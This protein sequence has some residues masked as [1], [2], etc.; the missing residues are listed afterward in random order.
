MIDI[1]R[2]LPDLVF[3]AKISHSYFFRDGGGILS[4]FAETCNGLLKNAAFRC[5]AA[6]SF[7]FAYLLAFLFEGQLL[8]SVAEFYSYDVDILLFP[9]VGAHF[10]GL[11]SGWYF[12]RSSAA[13]RRAQSLLCLLSAILALPF[14]FA[15]TVLWL[16]CITMASFT[17]GIV[18]ASWGFTLRDSV[19]AGERLIVCADTL[20][21]SNLLMILFN[22]TAVHISAMAGLALSVA[23]AVVSSFLS[24]LPMKIEE[25]AIYTSS[26]S[27]ARPLALLCLFVFIITID[28][29]L[30]Y[31]VL[32][33]AFAHLEWLVSWYW[34]LPYIAALAILRRPPRGFR[35]SWALYLGMTMI[36]LAFAL[37]MFVGRGA[38]GYLIVDTLMLGACG[39][40]DLFWW[41]LAASF[42]NF[43][44]NPARVFG[45]CLAAN[46]LGVLVGGLAG[47]AITSV[48]VSEHAAPLIALTVVCVTMGLLP[49][50]NGKLLTLL[51]E[52]SFL[53]TYF[54]AP[55]HGLTAVYA[56]FAAKLTERERD[57]LP[58]LLAGKKNKDIGEELCLSESTVKFHVNN[59]YKKCGVNSRT[60]LIVKLS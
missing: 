10:L 15:P 12:I 38:A 39:I 27:L 28:S 52:H 5:A 44:K 35:R 17:A 37:F 50:L 42:L 14:F 33:P 53:L 21:F 51:G 19:P 26:P 16:P 6:F 36:V 7:F 56:D 29:G 31:Q 23:A 58:L 4:K 13:A 34:A 59:I 41:S 30:M 43:A 48:G 25:R 40:F 46:V 49:V 57:L 22:I 11:A 2:F 60:E 18:V 32:N 47:T 45:C 55:T 1:Q 9:S 20:I 8:Y 54:R 3:S 24:A